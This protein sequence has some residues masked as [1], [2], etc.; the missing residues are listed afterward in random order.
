MEKWGNI[1]L[2]CCNVALKMYSYFSFGQSRKN[3]IVLVYVKNVKP[4]TH[5]LTYA[6]THIYIYMMMNYD[7]KT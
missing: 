5:K 2:N 6:Q 1:W 7:I 3:L 4:Y